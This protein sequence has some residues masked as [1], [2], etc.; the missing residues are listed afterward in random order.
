MSGCDLAKSAVTPFL[1]EVVKVGVSADRET[2]VFAECLEYSISGRRNTQSLV[3]PGVLL[4]EALD[5]WCS[6]P[7]SSSNNNSSEA[8]P[9]AVPIRIWNQG[10]ML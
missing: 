7:A 8:S 1:Q 4:I 10:I 9:A 6:C 5:I 2:T 3:V